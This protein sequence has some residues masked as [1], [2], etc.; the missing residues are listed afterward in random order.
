MKSRYD[1]RIIYVYRMITI[2]GLLCLPDNND[3]I[4]FYIFDKS[5]YAMIT[6]TR[7]INSL[8]KLPENLSIDDLVNHMVLIEKVQ[9]GLD[10]VT[11]GKLNTKS[12]AQKKLGKWLK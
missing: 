3:T 12:G 2:G 9:K 11:S 1:L 5:T 4:I 7:L 10:D 8:E 6:K